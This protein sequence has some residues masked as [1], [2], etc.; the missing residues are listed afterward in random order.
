M[1]K[2]KKILLGVC[3]SIAAY[4]TALLTR[5]LIK[6]G[7]EVKILM[8]AAAR[9]FITPL[10][11]ATLSKNPVLSEYFDLKSGEWNSH[12]DLGLWADCMV[13]APASANTMAKMANGV[14]DNLLLATYLSAR[15]PVYIAPAMDLDMYKHPATTANQ[16][17]LV[18]FG[19]EII[20]AEYGELASGL[21]GEGR[22]AE[23][24]QIL[25][26]LKKKLGSKIELKGKK[27]MVTAGPTH[28]SLD[29]V[30]FIGNH[31]SGKMGF[32][33]AEELA[34]RGADVT[35]ISGPSHQKLTNPTVKRE[36]VESASQMFDVCAS[37]YESQDITVLSAAV[38]DYRPKVV[39]D[40]KIKK[41]QTDY[42]LELEK[43]VDI[44]ASLA[45]KKN[46][47][48]LTVGFA[49]ETNNEEENALK[50]LSSKKFDMVV[51]NSLQDEGA[52]FGVD[53]NKITIIENTGDK[54]NFEVKSKKEVAVD[55][56]DAIVRKLDASKN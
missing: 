51:L 19:N 12:V 35:L 15:C 38:A 42:Q 37:I 56:V 48:Q 31:S 3:G 22:M 55:I 1:L 33:I 5:L 50:K 34:N 6:E 14:C 13:I 39:A 27:A 8:T 26:F 21:V 17:K 9:D 7:A 46:E 44:A 32:A 53:T 23:P 47:G 54:H 43:T 36:D 25:E 4:K 20:P 16:E 18:S 40:Q 10:T 49:L 2:G 24:E 28:E 29:P 41:D 30:R 11:L 52:G 45:E